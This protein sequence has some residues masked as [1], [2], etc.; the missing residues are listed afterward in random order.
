[1]VPMNYLT[2]EQVANVLT[3]VRNSFGNS[4]DIVNI[5]D[6]KRVRQQVVVP[7]PANNFE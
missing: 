4:G 5:D 7:P 3:Y 6:V 1:M 2:D